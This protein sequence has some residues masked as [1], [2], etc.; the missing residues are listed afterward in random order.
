MEEWRGIPG[1]IGSYEVSNQGRVRSLDRVTDRGRRWRGRIMTPATMPRGYQVVT[2]WRDGKQRT[3]LVH[4]LVLMAFV[5]TPP[6]D[7]EG[8]HRDGDPANNN[9]TNL[10]WGT[11]SDNQ[12][13]QVAHGTHPNASKDRCPAGHL[14]DE[15]NTYVYPGRPHRGCRACRR[16]YSREHHRKIQALKNGVAA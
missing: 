1:Y 2:L 14:Y 4:R 13:D 5:G 16:D 6:K 15:K 12:F 11:H 7:A 3:Q 9:L 10:D 8:L